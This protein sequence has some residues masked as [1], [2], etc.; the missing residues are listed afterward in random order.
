MSDPRRGAFRRRLVVSAVAL[1]LPLVG[2]PT[3]AH[4]TTGS[5]ATVAGSGVTVAG[6]GATV[7]DDRV[8]SLG[9][10]GG[11]VPDA[12]ARAVD[13]AL[14]RDAVAP[15]A[16]A[17]GGPAP[18][19]GSPGMG[20]SDATPGGG[21]Q[22]KLT[23]SDGAAG[24]RFG[25]S[26]ALAGDTAVVGAI[27]A[28]VDGN[29]AQGAAYVFTRD[30]AGWTER[31]KLT[32]S[33]GTAFD[34]FG[35]SLALD[36]DTLL[37]GAWG[38]AAERGAVYVYTRAGD[39]WI[40]QAKLTA[41]DGAPNDFF[42]EFVALDGDTAV[43]GASGVDGADVNFEQGAAYVF[44][45]TG[46]SWGPPVRL[47]APEGARNDQFGRGVAVAGDTVLVGVPFAEVGDN[48]DQ[49]A[50]DVFTREGDGWR[51]STRLTASDGVGVDRFGFSVAFDGDTALVGTI[52]AE[53]NGDPGAGAAYVFTRDGDGWV[54]RAKLSA[55]DGAAFD[56]FGNAVALTG[57]RA[58]V[59]ADFA[60]VDGNAGQGAAYVFARDGDAWTEQAKLVAADGAP[61]D[62]FSGNAVAI[63]DEA[64]LVGAQGATVDGGAA[65]GAAYL[66]PADG[67]VAGTRLTA[68]DG[69][70]DSWFGRSVAVSG[71]TALVG[72]D[73][74]DVAGNQNQGAAYVFVRDGDGWVEQAKL[75]ASDG[76]SFDQFGIS[77]ALSGD[78][79]LVGAAGPEA[80]YVFVR[81][82]DGWVERARLTASDGA[83]SDR[84]GIAVALS[85]DT[86]LVGARE[87]DVAGN[88]NQ[89]AAYVFVRNG[90][91]W[92][93]QAK[94][95]ARDG[96]AFDVFADAV[97]VSGDT[98]VVGAA[99]ADPGGAD[100][101][102]AAWVFTRDGDTWVERATL[103]A[104]DGAAGDWFGTAVA[105][106]GDTVVVGASLDDG[107]R[108]AAY[109]FD[110]AGDGWVERAK[111][112]APV[113]EPGS[114]FGE[115]V[116]VAG[117]AAVVGALFAGGS[118]G[119]AW[120]F[121]RDGDGW[122]ER[123]ALTPGEPA[124]GGQFGNAV[125]LA[126]DT[127]VVGAWTT[128]VDGDHTQGVAYAYRLAV[129]VAPPRIEVEPASLAVELTAG[130][131]TTEPVTIA[132]RGEADLHWEAATG[133][134]GCGA[135]GPSWLAVAPPAGTVV[136][137]G[138]QEVAVTVDTAGLAP[139][140]YRAALCVTSDDPATPLVA[141][142]VALT[143]RAAGGGPAT[144]DRIIRGRHAGPLTVTDG[145]TCLAAGARVV[146]EVNVRAGAGLVAT[147]AVV[148][149]PVSAIGATRVELSFTQVTGP[150]LVT[151]ATGPVSLFA[152]QVTGSVSLVANTTGRTAPVVSG[153]TVI[154]TLSCL[155]NQ[156]A[157]TDHGL[158]NTATGG[159]FG[160]CAGL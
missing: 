36:G 104:A 54:E 101:R 21:D 47:T 52:G 32:G 19:S 154:G 50:V 46:T 33:D 121:V 7:T 120:L 128:E 31:Q 130:A 103:T 37:V 160:Q 18:A 159:A 123:A 26:V 57:D 45:R 48:F 89:G 110:R 16:T 93:E 84:F 127:A 99:F 136:G 122:T 10:E 111:L 102:G 88:L 97:A 14:T 66:F 69:T 12:L 41:P 156:P 80:A 107:G 157:P 134:P 51:R 92:T 76:E 135:A 55:S 44:T 8:G 140:D 85:G 115:A 124:P 94:L 35:G 70:A 129:P 133:E 81:T 53:V 75:T 158:P 126:G 59:G 68:S 49:G 108:G 40:E 90:D 137:G 153:N 42:G 28:T 138:S 141:V 4:A 61:F 3:A 64:V 146:G 20:G 65:Q 139:G 100:A 119:A 63:A 72:A 82:G 125:T 113:P 27:L 1:A 60:A 112:T 62:G 5:G 83:P 151:G 17:A 23:A 118:Q 116:A 30:G 145:V 114:W 58:V 11:E 105:V 131:A 98:A 109:V 148:Q 86:A 79:A 96:A 73:A 149:G 38:A 117:R 71:D 106:A 43:V 56:N 91:A 144:C 142:P 74:T 132:N 25:R 147:A 39:T 152:D 95:T 15:A 34:R 29:V 13:R 24:D 67:G 22:L 78:T 150:V 143:V 87:A 77:V 155:G 2:A 6:S 9:A